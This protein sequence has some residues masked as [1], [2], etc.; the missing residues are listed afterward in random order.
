MARSGY[1]STGCAP[2]A[3]GTQTR[4]TP[5]LRRSSLVVMPAPLKGPRNPDRT[6]SDGPSGLRTIPSFS[7]GQDEAP[8]GALGRLPARQAP[9]VS[10]DRR[11]A[12]NRSRWPGHLLRRPVG[13][14]G[15]RSP[16]HVSRS[17][18]SSGSWPR[19][20]FRRPGRRG[21]LRTLRTLADASVFGSVRSLEVN[22][23]RGLRFVRTL[24][25]LA[26]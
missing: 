11:P 6:G 21:R 15:T 9:G 26:P 3:N 7:G 14:A 17:G 13:Q 2:G 4:P 12:W 19:G 10:T 1:D 23:P 18:P 5:A 8:G 20:S 25:T 24:R 16:L 22:N